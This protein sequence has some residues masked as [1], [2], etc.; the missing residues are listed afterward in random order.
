MDL[1]LE[2][3]WIPV[4]I[5]PAMLTGSPGIDGGR[6]VSRCIGTAPTKKYIILF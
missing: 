6:T 4:N 2:R 1:E 3:L 5:I